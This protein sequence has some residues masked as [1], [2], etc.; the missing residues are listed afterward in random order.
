KIGNGS[1]FL[2]L[3]YVYTCFTCAFMP[4]LGYVFFNRS[5]F[6]AVLWVRYM[7]IDELTY[8]SFVLP[9]V[10]LFSFAFFALRERSPD[11]SAVISS[12]I[13]KIKVLTLSIRPSAIIT[14]TIVSL[15][16]Y[17]ISNVLPPSFR[18]IGIFLYNSLF[19]GLFYIIYKKDFPGRKY[20]ATGIILF[21]VGD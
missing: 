17:S 2:E 12:F 1:F 5:N 7:P 16:A 14:M 10:L 21:I 20:Y 4:L 3:F 8:F 15:I 18:Q 13:S 6:L 11:D 9:C 19:A